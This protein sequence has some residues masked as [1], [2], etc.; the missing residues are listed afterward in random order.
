M[1]FALQVLAPVKEKFGPGLSWADLIVLAG[2]TALEEATGKQIP[3]CGGRTDAANG[4]GSATLKPTGNFSAGASDLKWKA[5][6]GM[7][8]LITRSSMPD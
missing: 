7:H 1:D 6:V 4:E 2:T 5:K 3:F 8:R